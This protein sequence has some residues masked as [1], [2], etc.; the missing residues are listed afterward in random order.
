MLT[1]LIRLYG[2]RD[3]GGSAD[4][5]RQLGR[6]SSALGILLNAL[7]FAAKLTA[8][9]LSGSIAIIAD[10]FN[11]LS[12]AATS[13]VTMIGFTLSGKQ[14]DERHPFGHGRLEYVS[15]L[16]VS[17]LIVAMGLSLLKSSVQQITDPQETQF[18]P[19]TAAILALSVGVK[20]Y[21]FMYNRALGRRIESPALIA[22]SRDSLGDLFATSI[23]L[24]SVASAFYGVRLG[25]AGAVPVDGI[26]GIADR[27]QRTVF[28]QGGHI[29]ADRRSA[30]RGN[31]RRHHGG[32]AERRLRPGGS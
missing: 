10:A 1:L 19:V 14:P 25:S 21:M 13:L 17:L 26:G 3:H 12:D 22:A 31:G 8:G 16:I 5:R 28:R 18:S 9:F 6:L 15:G 20:L 23:V 2:P 27:I 29:P 4:S 7:L 24:L 11:S 32:R 30:V